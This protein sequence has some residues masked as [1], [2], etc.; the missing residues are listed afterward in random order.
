MQSVLRFG[1]SL[2]LVVHVSM[3]A[4]AC[5]AK[6]LDDHHDIPWYR[7]TTQSQGPG[8]AP[9]WSLFNFARLRDG[10]HPHVVCVTRVKLQRTIRGAWRDNHEQFST[11][12][13]WVTADDLSIHD[14]CECCQR[15]AMILCPGCQQ[16]Q[17]TGI[18]HKACRLVTVRNLPSSKC[19]LC[20]C[21]D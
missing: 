17:A 11:K 2:R 12:Y 3:G 18:S 15:K 5:L 20:C 19:T 7:Y 4:Q 16:V 9:I 21:H 8:L 1:S 13:L 10:A 14:E 6:M